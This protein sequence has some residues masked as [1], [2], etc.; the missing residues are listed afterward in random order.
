MIKPPERAFALYGPFAAR[1]I[2]QEALREKLVAPAGA[3]VAPRG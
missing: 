3:C 1:R 2:G